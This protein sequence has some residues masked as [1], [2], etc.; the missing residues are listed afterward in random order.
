MK[1]LPGK[2]AASRHPRVSCR[3]PCPRSHG[4]EGNLVKSDNLLISLLA[5]WQRLVLVDV[6]GAQGSGPVVD[7]CRPRQPGHFWVKKME[8][9]RPEEVS[10]TRSAFG[11]IQTT[12]SANARQHGQGNAL[13]IISGA[14]LS[15]PGLR[16]AAQRP[17]WPTRGPDAHQSMLQ[18]VE[19]K[20]PTQLTKDQRMMMS[21]TLTKTLAP[22]DCFCQ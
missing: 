10:P 14:L 21:H 19:R 2:R 6:G 4:C 16:P 15:L 8:I 1:R 22:R 12:E 7:R 17:T 13:I 11:A 5:S 3:L 20:T 9:R 18:H